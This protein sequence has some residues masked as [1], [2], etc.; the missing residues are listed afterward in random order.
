MKSQLKLYLKLYR[1][2]FYKLWHKK[3]FLIGSVFTI[4]I[5]QFYFWGVI[6]GEEIS[7]VEGVG[8]YGYKAVKVNRQITEA[9]RG[10]LTDEKAEQIIAQYGFPS[11][12]EYDYPGWRDANYLNGFV[13]D[14]LSDGSKNSWDNY[15]VPTRLY[16][17]EDTALGELEDALGGKIPFAYMRGWEAFLDIVQMGMVLASILVIMAVSIVFSQEGQTKM[18]PLAFT[19]QEGK[20]KA[21]WSKITAVFILTI[22][23]YSV[24]V[25]FA[26]VQSFLV[27]GLAGGNCPLSL[28]LG[29]NLRADRIFKIDYMPVQSFAGIVLGFNLLAMLLLSAVTMCVSAHCKSNFSAVAMA[30]VL[31]GMPLFIRI[32]GGGLGYFITSCMPIFLVMTGSVYEFVLWGTGILVVAV[33]IPL[34]IICVGEGSQVYKKRWE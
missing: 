17:I 27:F 30:A 6:V 10:E 5:M 1:M 22:I 18:L 19:T 23:V 34:L 14:Y 31:W 28:A 9:Y 16:A 33:D 13:T 8:Y 26:A 24:V 21:V 12:R 2:E 15:T 29:K 3:S 4:L 20:G 7:T 32:A 25:L 11:V